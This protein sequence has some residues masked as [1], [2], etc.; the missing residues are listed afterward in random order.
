MQNIPSHAGDIRHLFRATPKQTKLVDATES[1]EC[2]QVELDSNDSISTLDDAIK[3]SSIVIGSKLSM[4]KDSK[5]ATCIVT[6][7]QDNT[8]TRILFMKEVV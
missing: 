5:P 2:I 1:D 6:D 3:V 8:S 7:I 4:L